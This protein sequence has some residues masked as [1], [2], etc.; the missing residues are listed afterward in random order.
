[1]RLAALATAAFLFGCTSL[2]VEPT[3]GSLATLEFVNESSDGI[4]ATIYKV[5][6][7]CR[8]RSFLL[9]KGGTARTDVAIAAGG[10]FAMTVIVGIAQGPQFYF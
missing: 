2:Y 7:G 1:M 3:T 8:D 6:K 4:T 10:Q 5:A 9:I